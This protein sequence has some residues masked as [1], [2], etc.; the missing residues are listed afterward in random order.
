VTGVAT[1]LDGGTISPERYS[2]LY[3]AARDWAEEE[4]EKCGRGALPDWVPP[5]SGC[6]ACGARGADE[7]DLVLRVASESW[8]RLRAVWDG[9][10]CDC[11]VCGRSSE[12]CTADVSVRVLEARE[13]VP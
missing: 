9:P 7:I 12:L 13:T 10:T 5:V 4:A 11:E 1:W 8:A 3:T 6:M 2:A